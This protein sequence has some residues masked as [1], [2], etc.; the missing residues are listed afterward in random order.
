MLKKDDR[1][2]QM[3]YYQVSDV[4]LRPE[5]ITAKFRAGRNRYVHQPR[6]CD[7]H[8]GKAVKST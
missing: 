2:H 8:D 1:E 6:D 4:S 3:V 7:T 5:N